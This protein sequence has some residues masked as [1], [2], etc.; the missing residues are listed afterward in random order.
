MGDGDSDAGIGARIFL[1]GFGAVAAFCLWVLADSW[2]ANI[3]GARLFLALFSFSAVLFGVSLALTGPL[4]IGRSVL[5]GLMLALPV[6]GLITWAGFRFDEASQFLDDPSALSIAGV[7][8]LFATPFVSTFLTDRSRWLEYESLFD[9]AWTITVRYI[10]GWLFVA[11]FWI[12]VF[13]SN[14]LLELVEIDIIELLFD[15]DWVRFALSGAMLGLGLAVAFEL[16]EY[17]SPRLVLRLLRLLLPIL[18]A[19]VTVF[20]VVLPFR[21]LTQLFGD[22]SS[23]G[24]LMGVS[25]AA[26]SLISIALDRDETYGINTYGMKAATR[27]LAMLVPVLSGLALWAVILRVQ[28]YSWTPERV[29]AA[30]VAI[31]LLLYGV[32]YAVA[33]LRGRGWRH[34]IRRSNVTMALLS[35]ATAALWLTPILNAERISAQ[36]QFAR[37]QSGTAT[38]EELPLWELSAEWGRAGQAVLEA[39]RETAENRAD[40]DLLARFAALDGAESRFGFERQVDNQTAQSRLGE[41]IPLI[42]VRPAGVITLTSEMFSDLPEYRLS[43]WQEGCARNDP[44]VPTCVWIAGPFLPGVAAKDQAVLLFGEETRVSANHLIVEN[45]RI[46]DRIRELY[47]AE[48]GA[49]SNLPPDAVTWVLNGDF[50]IRPSGISALELQGLSLVPGN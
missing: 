45:G 21:G 4:P 9:T 1:V 7:I 15:V 39:L 20:V 38:P 23:A 37:Y 29:L 19:V 13:L 46:L 42:A 33:A 3:L 8:V 41:L 24:V 40:P 36:S 31:V 43:R 10:A 44:D 35:L 34:A 25:I 2:G 49:W 48:S 14:A 47:D 32:T 6:S 27:I 16:R 17:V 11:I 5:G 22:F 26:I 18:L 30:T 50:A 12:V 28:Q